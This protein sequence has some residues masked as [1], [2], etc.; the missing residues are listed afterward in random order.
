MT[1]PGRR[2]L[3]G[4]TGPSPLRELGGQGSAQSLPRELSLAPDR[5][6]RQRFVAELQSLRQERVER[7]GVAAQASPVKAGLQAEVVAFFPSS[8]GKEG[9]TCAL[10]VL[11]DGENATVITLAPHLGLVAVNATSQ[12]NS[13]VRAGPLPPQDPTTGGWTVH[14]I[15]D[16]CLI[17]LIVANATAFVVYAA[18]SPV[19]TDVALS[20]VEDLRAS[21]QVWKL[22]TANVNLREDGPVVEAPA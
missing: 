8:C 21:L 3:I 10:S 18:P 22:A 16:H 20:G 14:A 9:S 7:L 15:I 11:G 5:S 13:A 2:V 17:E 12:G 4:W 19:A 1:K 6:L